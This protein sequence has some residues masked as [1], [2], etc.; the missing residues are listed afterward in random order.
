M[1]IWIWPLA[2]RMLLYWSAQNRAYK[3]EFFLLTRNIFYFF[4]SRQPRTVGVIPTPLFSSFFWSSREE[5]AAKAQKLIWLQKERPDNDRFNPFFAATE[6]NEMGAK[7]EH[8]F[9]PPS[10][11]GSLHKT[12]EVRRGSVWILRALLFALEFLFECW[13]LPVQDI[14]IP[15]M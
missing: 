9:S 14:L 5:Q 4:L 1:L 12:R 10:C 13:V 11:Q 8:D 15:P 2:V 6:W 7:K 3:A